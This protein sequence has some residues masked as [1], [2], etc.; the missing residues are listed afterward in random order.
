MNSESERRR[1]ATIG[2][3]LRKSL[4]LR[5]GKADMPNDDTTTEETPRKMVLSGSSPIQVRFIGWL[6]LVIAGGFSGSIWWAATMSTKMDTMILNQAA[7]MTA[8]KA[9]TEDVSRIKEWRVQ[10]DTVGS[11]E[12]V[13]RVDVLRRDHDELKNRVDLHMA[14]TTGKP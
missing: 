11:P 5:L 6:V 4:E 13:K 1:L 8:T 10:I 7:Q 14:T 9:V 12:M 2:V 3:R